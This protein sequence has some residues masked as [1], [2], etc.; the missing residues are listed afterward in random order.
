MEKKFNLRE[1]FTM[2]IKTAPYFAGLWVIIFLGVVFLSDNSIAESALLALQGTV[3]WWVVGLTFEA[4]RYIFNRFSWGML[5]I[6]VIPF[7]SVGGYVIARKYRITQEKRNVWYA[8]TAQNKVEFEKKIRDLCERRLKE[9]GAEMKVDEQTVKCASKWV[10]DEYPY[11]YWKDLSDGDLFDIY[12]SC[13][14]SIYDPV[15]PDYE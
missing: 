3:S 10:F 5:I 2:L 7:V 15:P 9:E 4:I 8:W 11:G 12:A 1:F 13:Y 6:A 14:E